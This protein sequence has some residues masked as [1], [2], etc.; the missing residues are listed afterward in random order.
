[1]FMVQSSGTQIFQKSRSYFKIL[2]AR[3]KIWSK[4]HT[5]D[6]QTGATAENL[7]AQATW[8]I[9]GPK[10]H[11]SHRYGPRNQISVNRLKD[12]ITLSTGP[13]SSFSIYGPNGTQK[14][15]LHGKLSTTDPWNLVYVTHM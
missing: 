12:N 8:R 3:Q 10:N 15:L 4:F 5:K 9:T 7:V 6:P 11:T 14:F 1:M 2:G 13:R